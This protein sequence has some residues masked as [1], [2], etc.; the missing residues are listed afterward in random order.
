MILQTIS[1]IDPSVDARSVLAFI[2]EGHG[3]TN[4]LSKSD[5][6]TEIEL[7][8]A[9]IATVGGEEVWGEIADMLNL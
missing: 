8:K 2:L 9:E 6:R 1:Q 5:I 3:T 4:Q 7:Y